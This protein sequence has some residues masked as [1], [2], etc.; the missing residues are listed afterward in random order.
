MANKELS[1]PFIYQDDSVSNITILPCV[2][3]WGG[4]SQSAII[5]YI[6]SSQIFCEN[7]KN[8]KHSKV[9]NQIKIKLK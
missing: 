1:E 2:E 6:V 9:D 8:D 5:M 4:S 3:G 7:D